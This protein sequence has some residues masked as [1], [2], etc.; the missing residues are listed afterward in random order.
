MAIG[1]RTYEDVKADLTDAYESRRR[2]MRAEEA[3]AGDK[4]VRRNLKQINDTIKLLEQEIN[5][6]DPNTGEFR[7]RRIGLGVPCEY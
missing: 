4:R 1:H 7:G 2:A 5:Q 6:Y 3:A